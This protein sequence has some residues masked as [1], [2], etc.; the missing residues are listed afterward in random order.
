[1][2]WSAS[3][4]PKALQSALGVPSKGTLEKQSILRVWIYLDLDGSTYPI[5]SCPA[6]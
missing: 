1:M 5:A 6:R 4:V 3:G 2:T